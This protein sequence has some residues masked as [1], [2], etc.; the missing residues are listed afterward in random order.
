MQRK[1]IRGILR[2]KVIIFDVDGLLFNTDE[3]MFIELQRA[4][5]QAGVTIDE[6]FYA[7]N[8]YDDCISALDLS[9]ERKEEILRTVR[10][11]YYTDDI[12]PRL[13]LKPGTLKTLKELS[14]FVS[15]AI[16]SE[17][18]RRKSNGISGIFPSPITFR[19]SDT[20]RWFRAGRAIQSTF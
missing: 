9:P 2:P 17:R 14:P 1:P 13:R 20:A 3:L 8:G 10:E 5:A 12:L 19:S 11:R 18:Q 4:L 6:S 16:G 7:R 15:L